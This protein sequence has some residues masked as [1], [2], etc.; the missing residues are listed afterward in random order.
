MAAC[1]DH[2]KH[3][4]DNESVWFIDFVLWKRENVPFAKGP[5]NNGR[6]D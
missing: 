4:S 2:S 1:F 5:A 6:E 3:Y